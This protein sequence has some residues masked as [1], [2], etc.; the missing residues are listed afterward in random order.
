MSIYKG[1]VYVLPRDRVDR[2]Q[3]GE[4]VEALFPG[5]FE[6]CRHWTEVIGLL[7]GVLSKLFLMYK[8]HAITNGCLLYR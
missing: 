7:K 4:L 3:Y 6:A 5:I 1:L 2:A 8:M